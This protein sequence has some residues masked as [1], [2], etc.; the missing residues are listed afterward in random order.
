MAVVSAARWRKADDLF[1][2]VGA[3]LAAHGL[4][5]EPENYSF[6]YTVLTDPDGPLASAVARITDG[7]LRLSR[8]DLAALGIDLSFGAPFDPPQAAN[9][10]SGANDQIQ[11]AE[12]LVAQTQAQV[13]GF[14][15]MMRMMRD[16]TSDFGRNLAA[17]AEEI[18]QATDLPGIEEIARITGAMMSRVRDAEN[19][20]QHATREADALREKLAEAQDTARRDPLTGLPN[21]RALAEA[22]AARPAGDHCF[23][24]VDVD[25]F[26]AI[27]DEHGHAVGDRVLSAIGRALAETCAEHLVVRHGGEEF[28][29]LMLGLGLDEASALLDRARTGI[30]LKRF[31]S[32]ET[33]ALLGQITVSGGV[34]L[35]RAGEASEDALSRADRLLYDAK[36]RGRDQ[37]C[38]G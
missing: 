4:G 2:R 27:N 36:A 21:R 38:A 23:A 29:V 20:L 24:L 3:F 26:K 32:R 16:E 6:V 18:N 11:R 37:V 14:A 13:D 33:N 15:D 31:R 22:L 35:L 1:V 8:H 12:R 9:E 17:S 7:G 19:K 30:A 28:A 25:K 5:P 10:E 34:T